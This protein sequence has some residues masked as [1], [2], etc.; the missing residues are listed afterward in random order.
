MSQSGGNG[1]VCSP[2]RHSHQYQRHNK[3][4][5][6][7]VRRDIGTEQ[8]ECGSSREN[9]PRNTSCTGKT[10]EPCPWRSIEVV[11]FDGSSQG[12]GVL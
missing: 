11:N 2:V 8:R 3:W 5:R 4:P 10:K 1:P 6:C 12:Q 9:Y 7:D